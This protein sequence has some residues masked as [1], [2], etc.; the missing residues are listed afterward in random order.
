MHVYK[1]LEILPKFTNAVITTG[2]FDGV[3]T[4]HIKILNQL[5]QEAEKINGTPIVITFYPHPKQ[6]VQMQNKVLQILNTPQE[7]YN[8]L[9]QQGI[10]HIVEVPFNEAFAKLSA[11]EYVRDFLYSK[12]KPKLIIVGHDHKFGNNRSGDFDFLKRYEH[13]YD[14]LVKEIP[15]HVQEDIGISSTKIRTA[16][17]SGAIQTAASFLGYN[18]FFSGIVIQGN[19]LG[20]TIGYP[21]ANIEINDTLKLIPQNGV[22]AVDAILENR[23]L[24]GMMNIGL[25][26][27]V[28]GKFTTIEVNIFNFNEDIYGKQLTIILK[29]RLRSEIKFNS[30]EALKV[31]LAKDEIEAKVLNN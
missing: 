10:E 29:N 27:T 19:M 1:D 6:V 24:K 3:H 8:L 21:T 18:Y 15:V 20:R 23:N 28:N 31:Q 11:E 17:L 9:Q 12:F 14:F 26:P 5:K 30:L 25:K 4:G 7:K 13:V 22:Y 2:S 16:L